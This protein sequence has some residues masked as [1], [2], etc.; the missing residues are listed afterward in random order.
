MQQFRMKIFVR[1]WFQIC[2]HNR[3]GFY[4]RRVGWF[5]K[6]I[7]RFFLSRPKQFSI[8]IDFISTDSLWIFYL[9]KK[10][11]HDSR[12][13]HSCHKRNVDSAWGISVLFSQKHTQKKLYQHCFVL[14]IQTK[15]TGLHLS[16]A[17]RGIYEINKT[18]SIKV[19]RRPSF[20]SLFFL[21]I[22]DC[23]VYSL[24]LLFLTGVTVYR[25]YFHTKFLILFRFAF[26]LG[27]KKRKKM[28][29]FLTHCRMM[30]RIVC[31]IHIWIVRNRKV[32]HN[33]TTRISFWS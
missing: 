28:F 9:K 26:I 21:R 1:E 22:C 5:E 8:S 11:K 27:K 14:P 31:D 2:F 18:I 23:F 7:T 19:F 16:T 32:N 29:F 10:K 3:N 33:K 24:V 6:L 4:C 17:E 15:L 13:I 20:Y 25:V 12:Q 30:S